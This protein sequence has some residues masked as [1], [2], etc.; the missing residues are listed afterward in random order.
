VGKKV[1]ARLNSEQNERASG[2]TDV[3]RWSKS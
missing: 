3:D 2:T 1:G